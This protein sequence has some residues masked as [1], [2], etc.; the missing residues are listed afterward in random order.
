MDKTK[1]DIRHRN[2]QQRR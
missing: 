1:P 2:L